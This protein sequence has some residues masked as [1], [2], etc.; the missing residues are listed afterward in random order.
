MIRA[1]LL[2]SVLAISACAAGAI[3]EPGPERVSADQRVPLDLRRTTL[4]VR[5]IE[6]SLAFYR[7][8]RRPSGLCGSFSCAPTTTTSVSWA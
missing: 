3:A 7:A 1:L 6:A 4:V 2:A 8:T 5:D